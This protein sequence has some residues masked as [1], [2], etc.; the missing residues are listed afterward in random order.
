MSH[1]ST[2]AFLGGCLAL[3]F[4][5]GALEVLAMTY[6]TEYAIL[7]YLAGEPAQQAFKILVATTDNCCQIK[8]TSFRK[9]ASGGQ[10]FILVGSRWRCQIDFKYFS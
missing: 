4:D 5:A 3:T 10:H 1:T 6:L 9:P 7:L 2:F 8:F